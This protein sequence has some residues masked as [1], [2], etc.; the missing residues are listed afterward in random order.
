MAGKNR[1]RGQRST[2]AGGT[3]DSKP[4]QRRN[5]QPQAAATTGAIRKSD[6]SG[7]S[8]AES[9]RAQRVIAE[10]KAK[11]NALL[12]KLGGA[13]ALAI[14]AVV[15]LILINNARNGSDGQA[16]VIP[17]APTTEV[18]TSGRGKGD[19][20]APVKVINYS[21][22]QCPACG[23]FA[24]EFEEQLVAD[25]VATGQVYLEFHEFAF[26]GPE[27]TDA[28]K[29]SVCA[30]EQDT[31]WEYHRILYYNQSGEGE[32][33][34]SRSRL[35]EMAD[36][37]GLDRAQFDTCMSN[38][39]TEAEVQRMFDEGRAAGVNST[40][41]FLVNGTKVSGADYAPLRAAIDAALAAQ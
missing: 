11:R 19:P 36:T 21:D 25:Y 34:F 35:N 4:T 9:R 8:G 32:G 30:V 17:T 2:S 5:A 38:P 27:S 13:A 16:L 39:D 15:A 14:I 31:F 26:L 10:R 6:G 20:N 40:P 1:N 22:Y 24:R 28:A 18:A 7:T 12:M 37:V 41:S 3:R 29:A 33:A 23:V